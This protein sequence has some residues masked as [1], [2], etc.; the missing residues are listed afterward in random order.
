MDKV[1]EDET[2]TKAFGNRRAA[3][4]FQHEDSEGVLS[5]ASAPLASKFG[6]TMSQAK[7]E[8]LMFAQRYFSSSEIE[9]DEDG[10]EVEFLSSSIHAI[11][12]MIE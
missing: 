9:E 1:L 7:F 12:L 5:W 3:L 2:I 6:I 8:F 4:H 10:D 11:H